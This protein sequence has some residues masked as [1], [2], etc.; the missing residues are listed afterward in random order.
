[1]DDLST[2]CCQNADC[3]DYGTRGQGNLVVHARFGATKA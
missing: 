2:F 3:P 1:M